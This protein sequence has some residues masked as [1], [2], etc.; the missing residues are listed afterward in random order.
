MLKTTVDPNTGEE[1]IAYDTINDPEITSDEMD[2]DECVYSLKVQGIQS[3]II[4]NFMNY[5][6]MGKL[7]LL[8]RI[9]HNLID[10]NEDILE[11]ETLPFL[12]TALLIEEIGNVSIKTLSNGKLGIEQNTRMI[13]K[14]RLSS[15]MYL[16]WY[17]EKYE[18]QVQKEKS[19]VSGYLIFRPSRYK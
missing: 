3:D 4:V 6:E 5:V 18:N 11:N 13:D 8:N 19:D 7:Q 12:H 10:T 15:L 17:I 14:D 9:D 2:T 1:F 16:L